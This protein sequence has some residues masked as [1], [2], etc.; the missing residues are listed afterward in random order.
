MVATQVESSQQRSYDLLPVTSAQVY[1][2]RLWTVYSLDS[3]LHKADTSLPI[4]TRCGCWGCRLVSGEL[5]ALMNELRAR[6]D[7]PAG[8]FYFVKIF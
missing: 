3:F 8:L 5:T 2:A 1:A 6:R 7:Y 4:A